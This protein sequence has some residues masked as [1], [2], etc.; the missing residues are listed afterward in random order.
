MTEKYLLKLKQYLNHNKIDNIIKNCC[1]DKL[2][3]GVYRDVYQLKEYPSL[4]VKIEREPSSGGEFANIREWN[5]YHDYSKVDFVIPWLA[6]VITISETGQTLIQSKANLKFKNY[7]THVPEWFTDVKY[8]N[9]GFIGKRFVCI[10]YPY[11]LHHLV[12]NS[13]KKLKFILAYW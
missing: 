9:F 2:G 4:V 12:P 5:N 1:G 13:N 8:D 3:S 10:D 11:I 6:P 7:P